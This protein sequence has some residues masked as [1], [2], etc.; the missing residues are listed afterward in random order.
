MRHCTCAHKQKRRHFHAKTTSAKLYICNGE[1]ARDLYIDETHTALDIFRFA[2]FLVPLPPSNVMLSV[3]FHFR[4]GAQW[5]KIK[6][7]STLIQKIYNNTGCFFSV[8]KCNLIQ[9]GAFIALYD[10]RS[11]SFFIF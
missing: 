3:H 5:A 6:V 8:V 7:H 2:V 11:V 9:K 10:E 1:G 4:G